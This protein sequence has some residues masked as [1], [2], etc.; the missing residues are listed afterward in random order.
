MPRSDVMDEASLSR[1]GG[2]LTLGRSVY[3]H[4]GKRYSL[5]LLH[6]RR[7][8]TKGPMKPEFQPSRG[9]KRASLKNS[10]SASYEQFIKLALVAELNKKIT[11]PLKNGAEKQ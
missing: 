11:I 7:D 6:R 1:S 8:S 5:R 2:W 9:R 4:A 10:L 3:R